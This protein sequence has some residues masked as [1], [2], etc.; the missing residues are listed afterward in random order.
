MP[1]LQKVLQNN[2][3]TAAPKF[4]NIPLPDLSFHA[5]SSVN[6]ILAWAPVKALLPVGVILLVAPVLYLIFRNTWRQLDDEARTAAIERTEINFRPAVA[7]ILLAIT[8]TF[9]EYYGGRSF[10][11]AAI[12]PILR[13]W[14]ASGSAWVQLDTFNRLYSYAWWS[15]SRIIGYVFVP[16]IVW[17]VLFPKDSILDMG[18]RVKGLLSHA[19]I[20]AVC[21]VAVFFAMFF[22]AQ[23][24]E[25]L[26]YYPFYKL[27]SRSIFDLIVWEALYFAQFFA[28][29]F[30]FRGW[31]LAAL[32]KP[33]GSSAIFVMAVPYC[34][35]HYGKP[36]LEAHGA[37][38][39]GIALGSLA[40]KT[41]SIY[42]GFLLHI[43]VAAAMDY[44]ALSSRN[45]IPTV[46]WPN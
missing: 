29:E 37:I 5:T 24:P 23:Q 20:Y 21:L 4:T 36:Y 1:Y 19:W 3:L 17:K 35:I 44:V 39:A 12:E 40:M 42:S 46:F 2:V 30:F 15:L 9:H 8:L 16:L 13:D 7:L 45:G 26:N 6:T 43:T 18:L 28:L 22:V 14:S 25:F 11:R 34:M 31:L 32:R 41:R 27:S 10:F 33:F 38:L